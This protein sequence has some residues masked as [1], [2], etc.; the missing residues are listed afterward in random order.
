MPIEIGAGL[1]FKANIFTPVEK[2]GDMVRIIS[3]PTSVIKTTVVA[4]S[5]KETE[6]NTVDKFEKYIKS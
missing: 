1:W 4:S 6:L 2:V 5:I 3:K